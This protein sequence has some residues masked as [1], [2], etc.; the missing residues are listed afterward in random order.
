MK[1]KL[2]DL[3]C[4]AGGAAMGYHRAGFEVVGVDNKPQPHYPFPYCQMDALLA[5]ELLLD[6]QRIWDT[7]DNWWS[8]NLFAAFHASPPC[9]AYSCSTL[10]WRM[11]GRSYPDLLG[12]TRILLLDTE[13]PYVIENVLG[14]RKLMLGPTLLCGT[15]FGLGTYRHRFFETSFA[16][17]LILHQGH[18]VKQDSMQG[19]TALR[20]K[21]MLQVVGHPGWAGERKA[22]EVAMSIDWM[23]PG[24]L[25]QAIPS[26]YTE[27]IGKY[28][29]A[30]IERRKTNEQD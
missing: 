16:M 3:F 10:Q 7:Q 26:A 19:P 13:K 21:S 18:G 5:M 27:Y 8:L 25:T 29:M 24:E 4:C 20:S 30:D 22:R 6:G 1:P 28:L 11:A 14:A 12:P 2:L 23:S 15:M 17:P 9:Q